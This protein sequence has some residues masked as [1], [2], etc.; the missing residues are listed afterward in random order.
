M[1]TETNDIKA[2]E[3]L[4]EARDA[5]VRELRKTIVGME[6]VIDQMLIAIF[7]RGHCLLV[8]VLCIYVTVSRSFGLLRY[9]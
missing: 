9:D 5:M 8:G 6:D 3:K 2:V 1:T 4:G 7:A